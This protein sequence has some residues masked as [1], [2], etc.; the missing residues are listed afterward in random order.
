MQN[1]VLL[2]FCFIAGILLKRFK[3]FNDQ[4]HLTLNHFIIYIS[5]PG[6]I[7]KNLRFVPV[8]PAY[9]SA[10]FMPWI[11]FIL[12]I[13][14]FLLLARNKVISREAALC[15]ILTA[16]LGNTSFVG[17]PI[18]EAL[19]GS[20]YVPIGIV[21]DQLGTFLVVSLLGITLIDFLLM[22]EFHFRRALI[23]L[24]TFP[25]F[26]AILIA[27]IFLYFK[28]P[29]IVYTMADRL[30]A[31][32]APLALVSVGMQWKTNALKHLRL[33]L[34]LGLGYKL[35][36]APLIIF[37]LYSSFD[38]VSDLKRIVLLEA[39]MGP[40]ITGGIIAVSKNLNPALASAM[41]SVGIPLS[42]IPSLIVK[43][44]FP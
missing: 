10:A 8:T 40:M 25:P 35:I 11:I 12:C 3:K 28:P 27:G 34:A 9:F 19:Y 43:Y 16:G 29:E 30:G 18:I 37:L 2:I 23:N 20:Q 33:E 1:L 24:T 5:L 26:I 6:L 15:L 13:P 42:L 4:S 41:V 7:I 44:W 31:T 17:I 14:F 36:L 38:Y 22:G 32:L 21:I 39:S